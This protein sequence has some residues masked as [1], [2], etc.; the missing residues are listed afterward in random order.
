MCC[1]YPFLDESVVSFLNSLP[2]DAKVSFDLPR[3]EGEK[4]LIRDL[5]RRLGLTKSAGLLKR[6]IQFGSRIAKM[7]S[8][9]SKGGDQAS[10]HE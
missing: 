8:G 3:G 1:R 5:A 10:L 4:R 9:R 6:A 2:M 7:E